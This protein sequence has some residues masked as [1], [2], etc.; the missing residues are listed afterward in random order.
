MSKP[1]VSFDKM[2]AALNETRDAAPANFNSTEDE[3]S[4]FDVCQSLND[5][6]IALLNLALS[7]CSKHE[8]GCYRAENGKIYIRVP[9]FKSQ[10]RVQQALLELDDIRKNVLAYNPDEQ[11]ITREILES[12][13]PRDTL[14][15][16]SEQLNQLAR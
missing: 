14:T 12:A 13:L 1:L 16:I 10:V 2:R 15:A 8:S 6:E 11:S 4:L 3:F 5:S 9:E 7:D